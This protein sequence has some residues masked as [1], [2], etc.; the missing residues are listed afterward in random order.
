MSTALAPVMSDFLVR[1]QQTS[2]RETGHRPITWLRTPMDEPLLLPGC[3]RAGYTFWQPVPW[4]NDRPPLGKYARDFHESIISYV[5]MC[6]FL[7]IFF[8]LPVARADSPL[9]FLYGRTF[10][11]CPNTRSNPP[12]RAFEEAGLYRREH[13]DMPLCYCMAATCDDGEPLLLMLRAQDGE[14]LVARPMAEAEP[15][16]LKLGLDR[17]LPKLH[18]VYEW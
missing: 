17:L 3:T 11:C 15:L 16:S 18:F 9:S 4:K 14:A 8:Q 7:E 5:S 12:A 1:Y 6:Q 2:V 10:A 13:P